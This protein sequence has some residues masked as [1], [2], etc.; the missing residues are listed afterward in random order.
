VLPSARFERFES[1][2]LAQYNA[3]FI[4]TAANDTTN[5]GDRHAVD[6]A[7]NA[8]FTHCREQEF[9]IFAAMQSLNL[10]RAASDRQIVDLRSDSGFFAQ[11]GEIGGEA[12]AQVDGRGCSAMFL[13]PQALSEAW[14]RV[15][16]RLERKRR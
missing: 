9:V 10:R 12:I 13:Q 1:V 2:A 15:E 7:R 14:L 4:G 16:V 8:S 6:R 3:R 11:M 5:L